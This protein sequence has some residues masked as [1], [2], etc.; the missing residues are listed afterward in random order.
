MRVAVKLDVPV[1]I[2]IADDPGRCVELRRPPACYD[3]PPVIG[4]AIAARWEGLQMAT[5]LTREQAGQLAAEL[6]RFHNGEPFSTE[7][8]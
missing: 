3:G 8:A 4:I 7:Q 1:R 5:Q 2:Y 6:L